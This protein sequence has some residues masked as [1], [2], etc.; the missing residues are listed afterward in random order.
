MTNNEF[1][2]FNST[3]GDFSPLSVSGLVTWINASNV[4]TSGANITQMTDLSGNDNHAVQS[5]GADRPS[6]VPGVLNGL[7]VAR[8]TSGQ[9]FTFVS[10]GTFASAVTQIVVFKPDATAT[11][12][13]LFS[14]TTA[15]DRAPFDG[16][17]RA[18]NRY[19][20][21]YASAPTT[22]PLST[23]NFNVLGASSTNN[24]H[25]Y[26]L[27]GITNG[28]ATGA[29]FGG[30]DTGV[31]RLGIRG[32]GGTNFIGDIAEALLFNRKLTDAEIIQISNWLINKY[33]IV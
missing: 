1:F 17:V 3:Q 26:Y 30:G 16:Y 7:P 22:D 27:N 15:L 19:E 13:C 32:A 18:D 9:H 31:L 10:D 2:F 21:T 4:E 14:K 23:V 28:V 12:N 5:T 25:N 33:G 29:S 20:W 6:L 11:N 24:S 8:F